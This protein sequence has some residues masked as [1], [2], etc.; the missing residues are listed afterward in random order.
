VQIPLTESG[1]KIEEAWPEK[2]GL[3]ATLKGKSLQLDLSGE[4]RAT[5]VSLRRVT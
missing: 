5:I 4:F 1:W 2:Q 3:L